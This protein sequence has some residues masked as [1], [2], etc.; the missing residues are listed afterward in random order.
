MRLWMQTKT[1]K[2]NR[3]PFMWQRGWTWLLL[4]EGLLPCVRP[5]PSGVS[6]RWWNTD[7]CEGHVV[8]SAMLDAPSG[9][10]LAVGAP[11]CQG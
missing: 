6:W 7:E 9:V 11:L 1:S 8:R 3:V 5:P 10:A 2:K 4:G